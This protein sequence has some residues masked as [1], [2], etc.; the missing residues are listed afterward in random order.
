MDWAYVAEAVGRTTSMC[1]EAGRQNDAYTRKL[2]ASTDIQ[3][4]DTVLKGMTLAAQEMAG[5]NQNLCS[6]IIEDYLDF[7]G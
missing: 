4:S 1:R 3:S 7:I 6:A 2:L 5:D